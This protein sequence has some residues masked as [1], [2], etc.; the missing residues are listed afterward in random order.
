VT[1]PWY[2]LTY[3]LTLLPGEMRVPVPPIP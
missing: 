1:G 2:T 3:D